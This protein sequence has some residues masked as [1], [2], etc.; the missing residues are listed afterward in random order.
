MKSVKTFTLIIA[1]TALS[2]HW[3]LAQETFSIVAVDSA[4]GKIGSA[5]ASCLDD[6]DVQGGV[7]IIG[8]VVPGKGAINTQARYRSFN[9]N[10]AHRKMMKGL[11]PS[12]IIKKLKENDVFGQPEQRQYGIALFDSS[13]TPQTGAFT[14]DSALDYKGHIVGPNYAIQGNILKGPEVLDSMHSRFLNTNGPLEDKLMAALQGANMPGADKRCLSEGVSSRSAYIK[15]AKPNDKADNLYLDLLVSKTPQGREPIDSL[16]QLYNQ[17]K[18]TSGKKS[19][20]NPINAKVFSNPT[21]NALEI[22]LNGQ[23]LKDGKFWLYNLK[24]KPLFSKKLR[25]N[26]TYIDLKSVENGIYIYH[27]KSA[28]GELRKSGLVPVR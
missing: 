20:D 3:A 21:T 6:T 17:W 5:G 15:V 8:D 4:T 12:Q 2:G 9:Q 28:K 23:S 11:S 7:Y 16:Q 26:P 24:G 19:S 27:I 14:G 1:F 18:R 22:K 25:D 13:G 10:N